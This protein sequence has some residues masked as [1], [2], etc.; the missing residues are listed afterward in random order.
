MKL[1]TIS[2]CIFIGLIFTAEG[3]KCLTRKLKCVK[4]CPENVNSKKDE[5]ER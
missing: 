4:K 3:S 2:I 1:I 5:L